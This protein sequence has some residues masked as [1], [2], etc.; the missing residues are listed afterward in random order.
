MEDRKIKT[1]DVGDVREHMRR[2]SGKISAVV[3]QGIE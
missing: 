3:A 1:V 2:L